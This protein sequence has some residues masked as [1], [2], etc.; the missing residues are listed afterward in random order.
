[1]PERWIG[2]DVAKAWLDV[3]DGVTGPLTRV[4]NTPE[5]VAALAAQL[6]AD[7]PAGIVLEATG[8]YERWAAAAL[9]AAGL[10]VAVVNPQQTRAFAR[11]S[12]QRAKTDA[13]DARL[14]ADF[15]ARMEPV[16]ALPSKAAQTRRHR[17][18]SNP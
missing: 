9:R 14:L 15:G 12:G 13:L 1:M 18:A 7:P 2:I 16:C 5:G 4:A 11:A 6:A 10:Q 17:V 3:A 8:G